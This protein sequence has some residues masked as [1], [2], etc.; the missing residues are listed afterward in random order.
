MNDLAN[1]VIK[2]QHAKSKHEEENLNKYELEREM[3][4][5]M[6][7]ESRMMRQK[8]E[9]DNMRMY[10][11]RQMNEKKMRERIE[12]ELNDEQAFMWARD[13]EN[14]EQ[15]EKRLADKI[16]N[17]NNDNADFLKRQMNEKESRGGKRMHAEEFRMNKPLL[18]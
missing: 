8:N 11:A 3:R 12:K 10:L 5:R 7:D 18:K 13:K 4:M 6:E 2:G 14:Y 15:E 9:Q 17:I 16:K 1:N